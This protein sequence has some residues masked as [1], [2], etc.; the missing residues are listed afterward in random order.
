MNKMI[1]AI[2]IDGFHK[3]HV[4]R[5]QY[6]PTLRLLKPT[7]IMVDTCCDDMEMP[8]TPDEII[9]YKECFRAVDG[10]IVLYSTTG[11]SPDIKGFFPAEF[12]LLPWAS[13]TMLYFG[14]HDGFLKREDSDVPS[15]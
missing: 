1:Q 13:N 14:Y 3:G 8:P 9:E 2:V 6:H 4:V 5:M 7:I 12:S 15:T 10:E 11:A